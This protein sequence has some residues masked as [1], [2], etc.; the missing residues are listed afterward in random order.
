MARAQEA[1]IN[2]DGGWPAEADNNAYGK[3]VAAALF[4][5]K[6][7]L[8]EVKLLRINNIANKFTDFF[9]SNC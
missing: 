8:N 1:W 2:D 7:I 9:K 6:T 3:F 4:L 5:V